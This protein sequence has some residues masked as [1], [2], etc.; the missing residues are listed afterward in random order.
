MSFQEAFN[1]T[2]GL[3]GSIMSS[4]PISKLGPD[5]ESTQGTGLKITAPDGTQSTG[6][7]DTSAG[8]DY[9]AITKAYTDQGYKVEKLAAPQYASRAGSKDTG[10]YGD[11]GGAKMGAREYNQ[12]LNLKRADVYGKYGMDDEAKR[13]RTAS[14]QDAQDTTQRFQS[15]AHY[16][17]H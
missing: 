11:E 8:A 4:G 6:V 13:L 9:D 7:V 5:A 1:L 15:F 14:R 10:V 2:K 12:G 17:L 16:E 3:T